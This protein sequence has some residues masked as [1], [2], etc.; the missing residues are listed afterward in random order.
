[1]ISGSVEKTVIPVDKTIEQEVEEAKLLAIERCVNAGGDRETIEVVE[2][3]VVSVSYTMNGAAELYL[4]VVGDL[5]GDKEEP[6]ESPE[7]LMNGETFDKADLVLK[8]P[9]DIPEIHDSSKGSSYEVIQQIDIKSYRPRIQGDLWY[10]SELDLQFLSDG[11]GI[12]SVGSCG[13]P[14]LPCSQRSASEWWRPHYKAP[15]HFA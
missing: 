6:A 11:T 2:I 12:L 1:M 9:N 13:V 8:L 14:E 3:D 7:D 15:G 10:L 4:R 5:I